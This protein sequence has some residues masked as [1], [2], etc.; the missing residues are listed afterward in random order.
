MNKFWKKDIVSWKEGKNIYISIPFTWLLP[1]AKELALKNKNKKRTIVGGPAVK[2]IPEYLTKV[3]TIGAETTISPL[4]IHNPFATFTTKGCPN[5]C[6][7]CAVP[8]IEGEFKELKEFEIK[9]L[10]CDNNF[11]ESS[12]KHFDFVIDRLKKLEFVDFNQGLDARKFKKYHADRFTE[13]KNLKLR[14]S[15]DHIS[16]ES[17]V[18]DAIYLAKSAGL[19]DINIYVLIG[20]KDTPEEAYYKL[21]KIREWGCLPYPM[22]YQPLDALEKNSY[23]EKGWSE[24]ELKRMTRYYSR[25]NYWSKIPYKDFQ[26][27]INQNTLF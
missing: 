11:L 4:L 15:L 21:E 23:V 7:F 3:A 24:Q 12:K 27:K 22:R 13:L 6:K 14:F 17:K 10:V 8:K 25:L 16:L 18:Y 9:P 1:K 20:Y 5:K 26:I 19:K 2:L